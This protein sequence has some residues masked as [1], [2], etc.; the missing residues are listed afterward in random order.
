MRTLIFG[1]GNYDRQDDG[2][3]WHVIASLR[4][5]LNIPHSDQIDDDFTSTDDL[6]FIFQL[7]LTPE[8]AEWVVQF[9]RVCFIDAHT[10]AIPE[11]I[12]LRPLE[13][14]YLNS[15]L[16]H[17][18][19]PESLLSIIQTIYGKT[20]EAVLLSVRGYDFQ[21]TQTL[22]TKTQRLVPQA[23]TLISQ[24]LSTQNELAI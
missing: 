2:V 7:Q 3:A 21:F 4:N 17:H 19:T 20:P 15:P 14:T 5:F 24:W 13:P 1:Y 23:V 22:S 6:V 16:T 8:L 12:L 9:D 10:G 11:E 18:L